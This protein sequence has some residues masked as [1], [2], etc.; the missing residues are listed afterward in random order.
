ME[1]DFSQIAPKVNHPGFLQ[2]TALS[3]QHFCLHT[4]SHAYWYKNVMNLSRLFRR[5]LFWKHSSRLVIY[6]CFSI[7]SNV[8]WYNYCCSAIIGTDVLGSVLPHTLDIKN[9][10][11]CRHLSCTGRTSYR[12]HGCGG[13]R[14]QYGWPATHPVC[15]TSHVTSEDE[16]RG[17]MHHGNADRRPDWS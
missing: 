14:H 1:L 4:Q 10:G 2:V 12:S 15:T 3:M 6:G 13:T 11:I 7:V 9:V 5:L 8:I 17:R 16:K